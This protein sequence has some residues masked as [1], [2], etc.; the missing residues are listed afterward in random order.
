[1]A[2]KRL[3]GRA[4][5]GRPEAAEKQQEGGTGQ[6]RVL[7]HMGV[8]GVDPADGVG[9]KGAVVHHATFL[10][11]ADGA[12]GEGAGVHHSIRLNAADGVPTR[13]GIVHQTIAI[14]ATDS[15][16]AAQSGVEDSIIF[17]TADGM[18]G[19]C[20][21]VNQDGHTVTSAPILS[22]QVARPLWPGSQF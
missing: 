2:D 8:R 12:M 4:H 9:A 14:K 15:F 1:M 10:D 18:I 19:A 11:V 16:V 17:N 7:E 3:N 21:I 5:Y 13:Y 20:F 6:L 22:R